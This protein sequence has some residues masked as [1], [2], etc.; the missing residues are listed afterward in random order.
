MG[1]RILNSELLLHL[2]VQVDPASTTCSPPAGC[3]R[4][5]PVNRKGTSS[6]PSEAAGVASG[7]RQQRRR[8][9]KN[10]AS[11]PLSL[12]HHEPIIKGNTESSCNLTILMYY[13]DDFILNG[14]LTTVPVHSFWIRQV[15][16]PVQRSLLSGLSALR[17]F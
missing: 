10:T 8:S 16:C 1:K 13:T 3:R 5:L 12:T 7:A 14:E 2:M 6:T 4:G 15:C 11:I 9:N 17:C